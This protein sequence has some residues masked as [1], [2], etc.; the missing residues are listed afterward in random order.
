MN[1]SLKGGSGMKNINCEETQDYGWQMGFS[2]NTYFLT[3]P[4]KYTS[5]ECEVLAR[6]ALLR[7]YETGEFSLFD[8]LDE[9][10]VNYFLLRLQHSV[11]QV[12]DKWLWA[13]E[14]RKRMGLNPEL[15]RSLVNIKATSNFFPYVL[16]LREVSLEL[17]SVVCV[18]NK[19]FP[20]GP[21]LTLKGYFPL[22]YN[23]TLSHNLLIDAYIGVLADHLDQLEEYELN[24]EEFRSKLNSSIIECLRVEQCD[25]FKCVV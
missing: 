25:E 20:F 19:I 18:L 16:L 10:V 21:M 7:H 9:E 6:I 8:R 15:E 23:E 3:M 12:A 13:E 2:E 17:K 1:I 22:Y 24:E 14:Q 5:L 4:K 11:S